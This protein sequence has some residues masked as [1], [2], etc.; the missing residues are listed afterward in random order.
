MSE[1]SPI[2][3]L[4]GIAVMIGIMVG[5]AAFIL[6]MKDRPGFVGRS[7]KAV[8]GLIAMFVGT[9][10][11]A[12]VAYLIITSQFDVWSIPR[13]LGGLGLPIS[14]VAIGWYWFRGTEPGIEALDID[15]DSPELR[16]SVNEARAQLPRFIE[17]LRQEVGE[18][19]IKF[20]FV[21]DLGVTEHIWAYVH[22]Y[23]NG[24]FDVSIVNEPYAQDGEFD[25]ECDVSESKVEDW[26]I[27]HPDG[28]MNG[29]FSTIASFRY[30][31]RKGIRLNRTMR[32]QKARLLDA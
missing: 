16:E 31:E 15:F 3:I 23:E 18:S 21:T 4:I 17:L 10:I 13:L 7:V 8:L 22:G 11:L 27:L 12:W 14:L 1:D 2:E 29:A 25:I 19:Y 26:Q 20:P 6:W 28:S 9:A 32:R 24:T 30:I 5:L